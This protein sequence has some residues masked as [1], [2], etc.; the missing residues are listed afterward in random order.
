MA[1]SDHRAILLGNQNYRMA[2]DKSGRDKQAQDA[3]RRQQEREMDAELERGDE[4]EPPVDA[5]ALAD[6]EA[7]LEELA[8]PATGTEVVAAMGDY[9]FESA[10]R[11]YTIGELVPE[12]DE[13]TFD[14]PDAIRVQI[15][16]P[17]VA[18][19]MKQIVEASK[20]LSNTEFSWTQ[21]KAYEM[22]FQELEA[23]DADDD[24]EGI[25]AIADWIIERIH[26]KETLPSSRAVRREAAKFCRAN[27]YQV[28]N[29][30]WLGI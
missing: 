9:E 7:E 8:F 12:T 1:G 11:S 19:A 3:E 20:T 26:D 10:E 27:G 13:E 30:E 14:S 23:I 28:R 5:G 6:V 22:T 16:R 21:R 15:L 18:T 25:Q 24:D 4:I 29:D 2:D 17:T